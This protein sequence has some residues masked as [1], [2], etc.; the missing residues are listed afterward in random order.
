MEHRLSAQLQLFFVLIFFSKTKFS[1]NQSW[2]KIENDKSV[3]AATTQQ[4]KQILDETKLDARAC[5]WHKICVYGS[6]LNGM[7][8]FHNGPC[9]LTI[10]CCCR[11]CF[12]H[13]IFNHIVIKIYCLWSQWNN[14][15]SIPKRT[16]DEREIWHIKIEWKKHAMMHIYT[17]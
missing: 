16:D 7:K 17:V 13:N 15:N 5:L 6:I 14:A 4:Q 2:T 12:F 10:I 9:A 3:W 1:A 11:C 8:T